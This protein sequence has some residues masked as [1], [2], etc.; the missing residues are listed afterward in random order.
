M[1]KKGFTLIELLV[2][3]AIIAILSAILFPVFAKA[4]SEAR[5]AACASNVK[6]LAMA[7]LL[8]ANDYDETFISMMVNGGHDA[9]IDYIKAYITRQ[10]TSYDAVQSCPEFA[11]FVRNGTVSLWG[12]DP[13]TG[14]TMGYGWNVGTSMGNYNDGMGFYNYQVN[15]GDVVRLVKFKDLIAPADT[16]MLGDMGYYVPYYW[17]SVFFVAGGPQYLAGDGIDNHGRPFPLHGG[18]GNYA[19]CDGHVKWMSWQTAYANSAM[20]SVSAH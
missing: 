6:E 5:R 8:Y 1:K 11:P 12:S 14:A 18:G 13:S 20:F 19:F 16:I 3:I 4:R 15:R 17:P 9:W 2:V 10:S 7:S